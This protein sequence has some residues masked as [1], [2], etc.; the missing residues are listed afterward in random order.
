MVN[1][2]GK[3]FRSYSLSYLNEEI[4]KQPRTFHLIY[5]AVDQIQTEAK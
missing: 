2:L 4:S 5:L 3:G 1:S